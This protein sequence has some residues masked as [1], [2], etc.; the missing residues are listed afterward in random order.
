MALSLAPE[1]VLDGTAPGWTRASDDIRV[2]PGAEASAIEFVAE[3]P[4]RDGRPF[5]FKAL[6][7]ETVPLPPF[8][9]PRLLI[10]TVQGADGTN[11][12]TAGFWVESHG[13]DFAFALP[14]GARWIGA[15]VDGGRFA[16]QVDFDPA[17]SQYRLR[18]PSEVGLKPV[19]VELEYEPSGPESPTKWGAP[20]LLDGGVV[21]QTLWEVRLPWSLAAVG[22][23][24]GWSDENQWYWTGY[25]WEQR[26]RHKEASL[27]DW[28][29]G[30][31]ASALAADDFDGAIVNDSDRYLFSRSGQPVALSVWIV[32]RSWLVAVCSGAT[33]FVGFLAIFTKIRFRTIWLGIAGLGLLAAVLVQPS[34]TFLAIQSALIGGVLTLLGLVIERL[35]ERSRP[36]RMLAHRGSVL[37]SPAGAGS[38]LSR[39]PAVGS[40]DSTAIRIRVPST[41]EY[42][43]APVAADRVAE[44]SRSSSLERLTARWGIASAGAGPV[45]SAPVQTRV[46]LEGRLGSTP[47]G[48]RHPVGSFRAGGSLAVATSNS[49]KLLL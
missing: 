4:G 24:R 31:G 5:T 17:G 8:V 48:R 10:K 41:M 18:L 15:R 28:L 23:P 21:L 9:V 3:E 49:G 7:L 25:A 47:A 26:G 13:P 39:S 2:E 32:P 11:T 22:V 20:R 45:P 44:E 33:L 43:A 27:N 38:S 34:V 14:E 40:D 19:L 42:C 1:I 46:S 16:G 29:L 35:L 36:Q 37:T 6:A 12:S 30:A